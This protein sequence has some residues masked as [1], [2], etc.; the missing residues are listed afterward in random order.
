VEKQ[1]SE[2]LIGSFVQG[3][4]KALKEAQVAFEWQLFVVTDFLTQGE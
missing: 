2:G 4:T 1:P 3:R